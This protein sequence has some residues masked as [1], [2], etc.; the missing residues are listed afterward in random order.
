MDRL[1]AE[2]VGAP[3]LSAYR[4]FRCAELGDVA[5]LSTAEEHQLMDAAERSVKTQ[6]SDVL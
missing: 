5:E 4:K 3:F 2:S 6:A 1:R